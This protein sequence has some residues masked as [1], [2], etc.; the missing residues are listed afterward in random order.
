MLLVVGHEGDGDSEVKLPHYLVVAGGDEA[1]GLG[2]LEGQHSRPV[3]LARGIGGGRGRDGGREG[4]GREREK[5]VGRQ[6]KDAAIDSPMHL[7]ISL[8][9]PLSHLMVATAFPT[10]TSHTR[11]VWSHPPEQISS[12]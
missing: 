9:L 4:G 12:G 10:V 3:L 2:K 1:A 7:Q 11:T 5:E 6:W 8:S